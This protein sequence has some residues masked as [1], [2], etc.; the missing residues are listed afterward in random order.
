[1]RY[2]TCGKIF[3]ITEIAIL[4][5]KKDSKRQ[6]ETNFKKASKIISSING[7]IDHELLKCLEEENKYLLIVQWDKIEDH[8]IGFRNSLD[9]IKWKE[10]LHHF[11]DPFPTVEHYEK[12]N[13][14]K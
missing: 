5:I 10:L 11:Y 7:Y 1:M 4:K 6:F 3:M 8:I 2:T 14:K 13:L 12:I 9:Y